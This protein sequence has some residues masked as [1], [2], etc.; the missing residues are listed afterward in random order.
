MFGES[1][2]ELSAVAVSAMLWLQ[3]D[4][5]RRDVFVSTE[6]QDCCSADVHVLRGENQLRR[7]LRQ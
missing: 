7:V 3:S 4:D 5:V 2:S 1:N 6:N